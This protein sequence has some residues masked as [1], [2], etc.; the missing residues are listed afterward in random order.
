M[1]GI[2]GAMQVEIETIVEELE[3]KSE[4]IIGGIK[5]YQGS[6]WGRE[7]VASVCGVGKVFAGICAQTMILNFDIDNVLNIGVGGS[8][9]ENLSIGDLGI[10]T[11]VVQHDMDT[12][13]LGDPLGLISGLD[14]VEIPCDEAQTELWKKAADIAKIR[15]YEGVIAS[16]DCFVSSSAKKDHIKDAFKGIVCEMEGGAIGQVCFLNRVPFNVIRAVSDN[17]DGSADM[18]FPKFVKKAVAQS[19]LLLKEYITLTQE[20]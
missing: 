5:F 10:A 9:T 3:N 11:A 7:V 2:I 15:H 20:E 17:A 13:P 18:D 12:T 19:L 8:L 14:I 1:L 6:L 4:K 16:G